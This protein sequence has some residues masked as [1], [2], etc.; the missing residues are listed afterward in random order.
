MH[1]RYTKAQTAFDDAGRLSSVSCIERRAEAGAKTFQS[2]AAIIYVILYSA[3]NPFYQQVF[4][5]AK[6]ESLDFLVPTEK[7]PAIVQ[8]IVCFKGYE[9][10]IEETTRLLD[11]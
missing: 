11:V 7:Q 9:S 4:E 5:L 2:H 1:H 10:T 6:S 8:E 3:A